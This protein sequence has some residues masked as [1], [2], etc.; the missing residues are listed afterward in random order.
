MPMYS[1][2]GGYE[3]KCAM[4]MCEDCDGGAMPECEMQMECAMP[5]SDDEE[6][7]VAPPS[8]PEPKEGTAK[9]ARVSVGK[10]MTDHAQN[11]LS[12]GSEDN[13]V[14]YDSDQNITVTVLL[15]NT[16]DG[17]VPS[18]K[19][20]TL[21]LEEVEKL[22]NRNIDGFGNIQGDLT[23]EDY[24]KKFN[25]YSDG[26]VTK[27]YQEFIMQMLEFAGD[28]SADRLMWD[29]TT[30]EYLKVLRNLGTTEK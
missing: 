30:P 26:A 22:Y 19:D 12:I 29:E 17:G 9:A 28:N 18:K 7:W 4:D 16:I 14:E 13:S 25:L 11:K 21:A 5:E 20:V 6:C 10:E 8:E 27:K 2:F 1:D 24:C 23:D 3:S 15:T